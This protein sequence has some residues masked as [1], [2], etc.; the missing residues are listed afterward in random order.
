MDGHHPLTGAELALFLLKRKSPRDLQ[1]TIG[2]SEL[3]SPCTYCV[4]QVL[5]ANHKSKGFS[6]WWLAA[7][8]GTAVHLDLDHTAAE[9]LPHTIR[10]QR[11]HL[12]ELPDYG[13]VSS[14]PDLYD[15]ETETVVDWKTTEREKLK[16]YKLVKAQPD[17]STTETTALSE[18][19]FTIDKY[20]GQIMSYGRG[21]TMAGHTVRNVSLA[22]ICRDG[23]TDDD[24]WSWDMAYDPDYAEHVWRRLEL[25][26]DYIREGGDPDTL[27]KH[28]FCR[29]CNY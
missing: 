20:R 3:G 10:E 13:V 9:H 17:A 22:F 12:G 26:W 4:G 18:A 1:K 7:R 19:R 6:P 23:K 15:P 8:L 5:L 28:P 14:S 16:L 29:T 25:L 27:T 2:A 11:V 24:I 21:L